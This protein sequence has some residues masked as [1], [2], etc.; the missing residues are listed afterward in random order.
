MQ[1]ADLSVHVGHVPFDQPAFGI[2]RENRNKFMSICGCCPCC[3]VTRFVPTYRNMPGLRLTLDYN[4]CIGC[5]AC[6]ETCGY[7]G[8]IMEEGATTPSLLINDCKA[9]GRCVHKCPTQALEIKIIDPD[10]FKK[11]IEWISAYTDIT[12]E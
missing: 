8:V 2:N 3:S 9:C 10:Y 4:K 1:A 5:G 11:S 12:E 7:K 6:V